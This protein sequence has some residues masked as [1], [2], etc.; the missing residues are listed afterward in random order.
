MCNSGKRTNPQYRI[1]QSKHMAEK[2]SKL[3]EVK[4]RPNEASVAEFI[5]AV[6]EAQKRQDSLE[7]VKMMEAATGEP[8]KMWG[9]AI[10]GFGYEV[11]KSPTSGREVEWLLVGFSPRKASLSLYLRMNLK[12]HADK[13]LR[14][15][16]HKTGVG[17]LYIN[18]LD[19]VDRGVLQEL[20]ETSVKKQ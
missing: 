9:S 12:E 13:L 8:P 11:V 7:L 18:K 16:K 14:L 19:D 17:C 5:N 4:T 3:A 1:N 15:G 6:P 2:K 20:I 10:V